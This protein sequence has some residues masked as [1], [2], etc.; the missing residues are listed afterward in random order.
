MSSLKLDPPPFSRV[1]LAL[2]APPTP[3]LEESTKKVAERRPSR[4]EVVKA[5]EM[6]EKIAAEESKLQ[7]QLQTPIPDPMTPSS[8]T[9][10]GE[11]D[12]VLII[13]EQ[14]SQL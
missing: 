9:S 13:F 8:I 5:P 10:S 3:S 7:E 1:S 2:P 12:D 11:P 6:F 4:F 14:H